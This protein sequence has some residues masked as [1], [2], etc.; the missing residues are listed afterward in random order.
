MII[1]IKD[2]VKDKDNQP[3]IIMEKCNQ[4]LANIIKDYKTE[5]IPEKLVLRFFTMI[6]IPLY[7]IHSKNIVHRDLKPDNI[8]Q[9]FIGD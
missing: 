1:Q 6:C 8:L 9:K 4:S 7:F 5:L 3:C 2:V